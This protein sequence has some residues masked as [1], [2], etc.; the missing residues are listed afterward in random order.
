MGKEP[1]LWKM[2][3]LLFARTAIY[4]SHFPKKKYK[5]YLKY[6]VHFYFRRNYKYHF[7][8]G[9]ME[10]SDSTLPVGSSG[11][12][13]KWIPHTQKPEKTHLQIYSSSK[14][15][16]PPFVGGVTQRSEK[17]ISATTVGPPF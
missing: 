9:K 7:F 17:S 8:F 15:Q 1:N 10:K 3:L 16:P 13:Q 12:P 5:Y 2:H 11:Q 6:K 4:K 14:I